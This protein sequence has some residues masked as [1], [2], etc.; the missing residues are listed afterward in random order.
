MNVSLLVVFYPFGKSILDFAQPG[1]RSD[2]AYRVDDRLTIGVV[3]VE[4]RSW[5]FR[6]YSRSLCPTFLRPPICESARTC[7]SRMA[8]RRSSGH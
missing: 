4:R 5:R 7:C 2:G 6:P 8:D 1:A 3:L